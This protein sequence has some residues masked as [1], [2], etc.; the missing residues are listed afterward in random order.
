MSERTCSKWVARYRAEGERPV[1]SVL[2]AR[3]VPHRTSEQLVEA[4]VACV[5]AD[6]AAEIASVCVALSTSRRCCASG[7]ASARGWSRRA[8]NRYERATGRVAAHRRQEARQDPPGAPV[9]ASRQQGLAAHLVKAASAGRLG[10]RHVCVDDATRL[11]YVEVLADEKAV[12]AVAFLRRAIAFY[13][14]PRHHRRARDDRQ[15]LGL[16]S[17]CTP[18]PAARSASAISARGPTA[19]APTARPSVSSAPCSAA[20]PTARSTAQAANAPRP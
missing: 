1:G 20:G 5:A 4:I 10:V 14:P 3:S 8:A 2:G 9:T 13:A 7:W 19:R 11:A 15:R 17:L 16:R 6:D 18:S 12:T